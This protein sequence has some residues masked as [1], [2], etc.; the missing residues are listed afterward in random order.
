MPIHYNK[1]YVKPTS[2]AS[3]C[4]NL[5]CGMGSISLSKPDWVWESSNRAWPE[6]DRHP[7]F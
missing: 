7:V 2:L 5:E 6:R 1:K 4:T 3:L